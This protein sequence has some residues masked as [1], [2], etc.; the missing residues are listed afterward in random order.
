MQG[1]IWAEG[2]EKE[3]K[4]SKKKIRKNMSKR[5]IEKKYIEIGEYSY[6]LPQ[7]SN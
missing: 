2:K 6:C 1:N 4:K 3:R 7:S 5:E